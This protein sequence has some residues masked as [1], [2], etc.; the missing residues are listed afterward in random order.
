MHA[1][2]V[3][4]AGSAM[5]TLAGTLDFHAETRWVGDTGTHS[6]GC[7]GVKDPLNALR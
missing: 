2:E 6:G 1:A 3:R 7:G 4:E 5:G